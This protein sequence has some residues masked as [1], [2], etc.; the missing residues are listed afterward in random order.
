[1]NIFTVIKESYNKGLWANSRRLY[2]SEAAGVY[3]EQWRQIGWFIASFISYFTL[4]GAEID[5]GI[6][7]NAGIVGIGY[8]GSCLW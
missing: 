4:S 8:P 2:W 7:K 1:M 3:I 5:I 6:L